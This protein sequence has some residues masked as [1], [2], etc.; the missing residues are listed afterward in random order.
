MRI[1]WGNGGGKGGER[2]EYDEGESEAELHF[3]GLKVGFGRS[4]T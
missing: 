3:E 4:M 1:G 2:V